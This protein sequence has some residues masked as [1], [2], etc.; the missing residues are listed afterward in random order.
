MLLTSESFSGP[1]GSREAS[2]QDAMI[3]VRIAVMNLLTGCPTAKKFFLTSSTDYYFF[4]ASHPI[5]CFKGSVHISY[6]YLI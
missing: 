3:I 2:S 1:G 4:Y 6:N 5:L